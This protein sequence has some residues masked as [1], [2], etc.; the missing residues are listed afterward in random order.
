[1][2]ARNILIAL[3]SAIVGAFV[4][5][6]VLHSAG[7]VTMAKTDRLSGPPSETAFMPERFGVPSSTQ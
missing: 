5:A 1:M 3:G 2:N 6:L 7:P 4:A